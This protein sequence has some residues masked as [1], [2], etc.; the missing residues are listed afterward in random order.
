LSEGERRFG[1]VS[2]APAGSATDAG[3]NRRAAAINAA[4]LSLASLLD[5]PGGCASATDCR[6]AAQLID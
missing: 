5:R 3:E 1:G 6:L 2:L 4:G